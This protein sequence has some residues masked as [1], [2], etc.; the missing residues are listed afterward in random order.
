MLECS[1]CIEK[2][3]AQWGVLLNICIVGKC[4][5]KLFVV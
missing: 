4:I 5:S 3:I 1:H 2:Y